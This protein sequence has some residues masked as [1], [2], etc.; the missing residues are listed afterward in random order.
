MKR[1]R[2]YVTGSKHVDE[3]RQ[4]FL[5]DD[6]LVLTIPVHIPE[7]VLSSTSTSNQIIVFPGVSQFKSDVC[8]ILETDYKFE[9]IEDVYEGKLQK[10]YVSNRPDSI[11]VYFDTYF[12]LVNAEPAI[13]RL[14]ITN[15]PA[16][17]SGKIFCYIRLRFSDHTLFDAGDV[18]HR[19]FIADNASKYV[20]QREGITHAIP[21]EEIV[22]PESVVYRYYNKAIEHLRSDLDF[23][24]A[25]WVKKADD[26][27]LMFG[28]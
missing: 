15:L 20:S 2:R 18:L 11:S 22:L 19:Q 16:P 10:G 28:R 14:G 27:R 12:D 24:I 3:D 7:S 17:E 8:D 25:S 1:L 4:E 6:K 13:K 21:E 9:V 23:R 26:Y 5:L